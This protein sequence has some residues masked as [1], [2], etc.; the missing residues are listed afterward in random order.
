MKIVN[1][2]LKIAKGGFTLIELLV[3]VAV[4]MILALLVTNSLFSI[5]KSNAKANIMKEIRQN[6]AYALD[7]M[8]KTI[9]GSVIDDAACTGMA[10]SFLTVKNPVSGAKITFKCD[11][12]SDP[13]YIASNSAQ[14]TSPTVT[15]E[16]CGGVFK[17]ETVDSVNKKVTISFTLKQLG[18]PS[19]PEEMARQTFTKTIFLRNR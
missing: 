18:A 12:S 1:C 6:G 9:S 11:D 2:K 19:R 4:F 13:A 8:D 10:G 14:L 7:V 5:L 3:V 17:C 15:I 16:S